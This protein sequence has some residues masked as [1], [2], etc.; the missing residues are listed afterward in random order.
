MVW[1]ERRVEALYLPRS[2]GSGGG[3]G[4]GVKWKWWDF[5]IVKAPFILATL[6]LLATL[7]LTTKHSL[8]LL[9][10][11]LL[12]VKP[13]MD[14][15]EFWWRKQTKFVECLCCVFAVLILM[16]SPH[17]HAF[18]WIGI[19]REEEQDEEEEGFPL[20]IVLCCSFSTVTTIYRHVYKS[21]NK[22]GIVKL[23]CYEKIIGD[24]GEIMGIFIV[25][26][27]MGNKYSNNIII[28]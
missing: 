2:D 10:C 27:E 16:C 20:L 7:L 15:E 9:L 17:T 19:G 5:E 4:G 3:G 25:M 6:T 14:F 21:R 26:G 11:T 8:L 18:H 23:S 13:F 22:S 24:S 1:R 28:G 12:L